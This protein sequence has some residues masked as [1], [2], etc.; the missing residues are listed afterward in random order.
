MPS[1][2]LSFVTFSPRFICQHAASGE[3][4]VVDHGGIV[5][6][7]F[8]FTMLLDKTFGIIDRRARAL[9]GVFGNRLLQVVMESRTSMFTT[10]HLSKAP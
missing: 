6:V 10:K 7:L 8:R 2:S 5:G 9:D 4:R 1:A 3:Y